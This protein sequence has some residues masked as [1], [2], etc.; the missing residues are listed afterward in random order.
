[1]DWF[2]GVAAGKKTNSE[3]FALA[4]S[5][6][7]FRFVSRAGRVDKTVADAHHGAI[8]CIRWSP[9]GAALVTSKCTRTPPRASHTIPSTLAQLRV[10]AN[11]NANANANATGQ[12]MCAHTH[13]HTHTHRCWPRAYLAFRHHGLSVVLPCIAS[14]MRLPTSSNVPIASHFRFRFPSSAGEDGKVKVWSRSG[15]LRTVLASSGS[16]VYSA[17]WSRESDVVVYATGKSIHVK[18]LQPAGKPET[19]KAH[20]GIILCVD[21]NTV[22]EKI[23]TGSEDRKYKVWDS[24]G[25]ILYSSSA[26][27]HPILST[28]WSPD[29]NLFAIGS[30]NTI[31]LCDQAGWSHS[32]VKPKNGAV[33]K[34]AWS[35]DGTRVAAGCAD[36]NVVF[37]NVLEQRIDWRDYEVVLKTEDT[38]EVRDI[39]V[40]PAV[41]VFDVV[42]HLCG[43]LSLVVGAVHTLQMEKA[44]RARM[45]A[46]LSWPSSKH[47]AVYTGRRS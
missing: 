35:S 47:P 26:H 24:Y 42:T 28:R 22:N 16:P 14:S 38:I 40:W 6:G 7:K 15:M 10:S 46:V 30:Y 17:S 39:Q 19:W 44:D 29:G 8:T 41:P 21:W 27:D 3:F 2:P 36:G 20:D 34:L 11:A 45:H 32:L 4:A 37:G 18:P 33:Y 12:R 5:D 9:D 13:T 25:Q 1:M 23:L 31:R 43:L